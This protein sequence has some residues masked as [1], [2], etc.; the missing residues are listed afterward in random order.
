MR[1][2]QTVKTRCEIE[3]VIKKYKKA[4]ESLGIC[5]E[6]IILYG[7]YTSGRAEEGSDIDLLVVSSDFANKNIR[8]RLELLGIASVRIMEP[9]QAQGYTPGELNEKDRSSFVKEILEYGEVAA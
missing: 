8:E 2:G 9:I 3:E 4:L 5:A 7:S 6:K 1:G